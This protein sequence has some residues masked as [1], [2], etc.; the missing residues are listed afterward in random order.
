MIVTPI[1]VW[2]PLTCF[3]NGCRHSSWIIR[4]GKLP[5]LQCMTFFKINF[6]NAV[7]LPGIVPGNYSPACIVGLVFPSGVLVGALLEAKGEYGYREQVSISHLPVSPIPSQSKHFAWIA[8]R[9]V[10]LP[11]CKY[12]T[13][14]ALPLRP[15]PLLALSNISIFSSLGCFR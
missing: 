6:S 13:R 5:Y 10:N 11:P 9:C 14:H 1:L 7:D 8:C 15:P 4:N 3:R 12:F 2:A